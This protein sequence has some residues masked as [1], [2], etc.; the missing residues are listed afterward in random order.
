MFGNSIPLN[1]DIL[2]L[3]NLSVI[4]FCDR[5]SS[6]SNSYTMIYWALE[7]N[8]GITVVAI[9]MVILSSGLSFGFYDQAFAQVVDPSTKISI[10]PGG[11]VPPAIP[12]SPGNVD[13]S[14]LGATRDALCSTVLFDN[15]N[16]Q[17]Y[18]PGANNIA[19]VDI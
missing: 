1:F 4:L 18:F 12:P 10:G 5:R 11:G 13:V 19:A 8:K 2:K 14:T 6:L 16:H 3:A 17:R 9:I 15:S 7:K